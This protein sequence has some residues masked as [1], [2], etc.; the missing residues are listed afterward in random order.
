VLHVDEQRPFKVFAGYE[1]SGS[2]L[3][4]EDRVL[5]GFNWGKAFGLTDNQ[6]G[7]QFIGNPGLDKLR[8]HSASYAFPLPWRN[9]IRVFGSYVDVKGDVG[10]GVTLEGNSYQASM[11]YEMPL[12]FLGRYQHQW[13]LGLDYKY[14]ENNIIFGVPS[15]FNTP[16]EIFQLAAGYSGVLP[17]PWGQTG[18]GAQ[19]YYSPGGLTDKNSDAAFGS[20]R[21]A[22]AHYFYTRLSA[23]R[24]TKL[25]VTADWRSK[26]VSDCF[27]WDIR[28][29][30]QVTTENLLPSEQLGLGGYATARGY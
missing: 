4:D 26:S 14:S 21:E 28:A 23:E 7:Y 30:G 22:K 5:A 15:A 24:A 12:P 11:R 13:S 9:M 3:A 6:F 25:P 10:N 17:D 16:T 20:Y 1:D 19:M 8:A 27:S 29:L 18:V 2:R